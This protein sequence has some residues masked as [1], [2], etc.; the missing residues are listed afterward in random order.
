MHMPRKILLYVETGKVK[1]LLHFDLTK[2][3][4]SSIS[5]GGHLRTAVLRSWY[6]AAN[7]VGK[8]WWRNRKHLVYQMFGYQGN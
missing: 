8:N 3:T 7:S 1:F 5:E 6:N 4:D 2:V